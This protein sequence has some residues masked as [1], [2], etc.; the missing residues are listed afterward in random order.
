MGVIM[1]TML[2]GRPPFETSTVDSTYERIRH[3]RYEFPAHIAISP[4]AKNMISAILAPNAKA[5][6]SL[7][8]LLSHPFFT[9]SPFP[10]QL[11]LSCKTTPLDWPHTVAAEASGVQQENA[12][13]ALQI[14]ITPPQPTNATS[15]PSATTA[16]TATQSTATAAALAPRVALATRSGFNNLPTTAA[17]TGS[18]HATETQKPAASVTAA[19]TA[20]T[21]AVRPTTAPITS[22][23][24]PTAQVAPLLPSATAAAAAVNARKEA[25]P[26][27]SQQQQQQQ[28]PIAIAVP[29]RS[30]GS[31]AVAPAS[32]GSVTERRVTRRTSGEEARNIIA[33]TPVDDIDAV[34]TAM[35]SV[36]IDSASAGAVA[37]PAA[38]IEVEAA[39]GAGPSDAAEDAEEAGALRKMHDE[40]ER[41]F[42]GPSASAT[43]STVASSA[44]IMARNTVAAAVPP[45]PAPLAHATLWVNK[46]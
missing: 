7:A 43:E 20:R 38:L 3:N 40:I 2:I 1:Y 8:Q 32:H 42:C 21:A 44:S 45:Q 29:K 10:K 19:P 15:K 6:P 13:A 27:V 33:S 35:H 25:A 18:A 22:T 28:Q 30:S 41:S 46:W 34:V 9:Q 36:A 17:A 16:A 4:A 31:A 39:G 14:V 12:P 24:A 26:S 5:R 23:V 11:P 37:A